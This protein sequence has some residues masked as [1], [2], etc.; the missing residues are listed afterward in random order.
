MTQRVVYGIINTS[1]MGKAE[2]ELNKAT[3][4]GWELVEFRVASS[5][6][7]HHYVILMRRLT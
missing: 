2:R 4:A 5:W 7:G 6:W 1:R 3:E